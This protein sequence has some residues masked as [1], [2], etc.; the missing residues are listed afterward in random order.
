MTQRG[1]SKLLMLQ[2]QYAAQ[3][4]SVTFAM[5]CKASM[6]EYKKL[7]TTQP[8]AA[9]A[10]LLRTS[11]VSD[12]DSELDVNV[13]VEP[14]TSP[15]PGI[16]IPAQE[17]KVSPELSIRA[18][19]S[20]SLARGIPSGKSYESRSIDHETPDLVIVDEYVLSQVDNPI[21]VKPDNLLVGRQEVTYMVVDG[22]VYNT[23]RMTEM[24]TLKIPSNSDPEHFVATLGVMK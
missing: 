24:H 13:E 7:C 15:L 14:A 5:T 3:G 9:K 2:Q 17:E 6:E 23:V 8:A 18:R 21:S 4:Q 10:Y 1:G 19:N 11:S 12:E 16:I 20:R 22:I